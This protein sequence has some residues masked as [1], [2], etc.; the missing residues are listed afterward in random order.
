MNAYQYA[1]QSSR[2][3]GVL[4]SIHSCPSLKQGGAFCFYDSRTLGIL[5]VLPLLPLPGYSQRPTMDIQSLRPVRPSLRHQRDSR[6]LQ[7]R[8][9]FRY[10]PDGSI[11]CHPEAVTGVRTSSTYDPRPLR[12]YWV[13]RSQ[14]YP[15][16]AP[17]NHWGRKRNTAALDLSPNNDRRN[18]DTSH[19]ASI[20]ALPPQSLAHSIQ[21]RASRSLRKHVS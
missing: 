10:R 21:P 6:H 5:H 13:A 11:S 16:A 8:S 2:K 20:F 12:K 14:P 3:A 19:T 1:E 17:A 15:L 9:A 18:Y 7:S 4:Q